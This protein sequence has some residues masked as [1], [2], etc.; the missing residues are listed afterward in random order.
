MGRAGANDMRM[1]AVIAGA[2]AAASLCEWTTQGR[3][4]HGRVFL[5]GVGDVEGGRFGDGKSGAL[6]AVGLVAADTECWY[7]GRGAGEASALLF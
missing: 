7:R 2:A 4:E 5:G 6:Q 3:E 1:I